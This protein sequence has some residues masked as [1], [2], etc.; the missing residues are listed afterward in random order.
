M[1][2]MFQSETTNQDRERA[3]RVGVK[4][5]VGEVFNINVNNDVN[6]SE[7]NKITLENFLIEL[8]EEILRKV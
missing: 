1:D 2:V 3:A 4:V 5:G 7:S 6:T 8:G